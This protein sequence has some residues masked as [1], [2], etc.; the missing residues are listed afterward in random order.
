M[1][2]IHH[3]FTKALG[4][5]LLKKSSGTLKITDLASLRKNAI[6]S[7]FQQVDLPVS[8]DPM[9]L[10]KWAAK[11]KGKNKS[12]YSFLS[13]SG[14]FANIKNLLHKDRGEIENRVYENVVGELE[15]GNPS[16]DK[17]D[18]IRMANDTIGKFSKEYKAT[19]TAVLGS[20]QEYFDKVAEAKKIPKETRE[21]FAK[22][23]RTESVMTKLFKLG[24]SGAKIKLNNFTR[25]PEI[26]TLEKM[27]SEVGHGT[28]L[29]EKE[30]LAKNKVYIKNLFKGIL[31]L[32]E[33]LR[34]LI[35]YDQKSKMQDHLNSLAEAL[36]KGAI[37][38]D[39]SLAV[40]EMGT[41]LNNFRVK[42]S[43]L[44]EVKDRFLKIEDTSTKA[45]EI[46][47]ASTL[48]TEIVNLLKS[49]SAR[50]LNKLIQE[51][52]NKKDQGRLIKE[53]GKS[54]VVL[55]NLL[56]TLVYKGEVKNVEAFKKAY[57]GE[58]QRKEV[59]AFAADENKI[60]DAIKNP[61][62]MNAMI[63]KGFDPKK[64]ITPE[65]MRKI[66]QDIV[67]NL[68]EDKNSL[69]RSMLKNKK[70]KKYMRAQGGDLNKLELNRLIAKVMHE[71]VENQRLGLEKRIQERFG[72]MVENVVG[73][74]MFK[75][76]VN[77]TVIVY[78]KS[79]LKSSIQSVV[80]NEVKDKFEFNP[81]TVDLTKNRLFGKYA[82]KIGVT[83]LQE[84]DGEI[85]KELRDM[86][87]RGSKA[88]KYLRFALWMRDFRGPGKLENLGILERL[89]NILDNYDDEIK[90]YLAGMDD[91]THPGDREA[92]KKYE[93]G[94]AKGALERKRRVYLR[95]RKGIDPDK[96]RKEENANIFKMVNQFV[97]N[98][99]K[100]ARIYA[101][102]KT[103]LGKLGKEL[104]KPL[105][106]A[107]LEIFRQLRK[108]DTILIKDEMGNIKEVPLKGRRLYQEHAAINQMFY[109]ILQQEVNRKL[110]QD[111]EYIKAKEM[112]QF[113]MYSTRY[114]QLQRLFT[115][116]FGTSGPTR[117][118]GLY[119]ETVARESAAKLMNFE[120]SQSVP[121]EDLTHLLHF[122]RQMAGKGQENVGDYM[123]RSV[124]RTI[125]NMIENAQTIEELEEVERYVSEVI[126]MRYLKDIERRQGG[127]GY[128]LRHST[129]QDFEGVPEERIPKTQY[130]QKFISFHRVRIQE[131]MG[132]ANTPGTTPIQP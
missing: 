88:S 6:G 87:N 113:Q 61:I 108:Q 53:L 59:E 120:V 33:P 130:L 19:L 91:D 39:V 124:F 123:T 132:Q 117:N 78:Y 98:N 52:V 48:E 86:A 96:L 99:P 92:G 51:K 9:D 50:D 68:A 25:L 22:A 14:N 15:K 44:I 80:F 77:G 95:E 58:L 8:E 38:G 110:Y 74:D 65:V 126:P 131:R 47:S 97:Q 107:Q 106:A 31:R 101:M 114:E 128:V 21:K 60:I 72:S 122:G 79:S 45:F 56:R 115:H 82:K 94:R 12:L 36:P 75:R 66:R 55:A 32:P 57:D 105:R 73:K 116:Q 129:S 10:F 112:A 18:I 102:K 27:L 127:Q 37:K 42:V 3:T 28:Y 24:A 2:Y 49:G 54:S 71:E 40:S 84:L 103:T 109:N 17:K 85:M 90:L 4:G 23:Y 118:T 111:P 69:V 13:K 89:N 41:M 83:T 93:E 64:H 20:Y 26:S 1:P 70:I 67:E 30:R 100:L 46:H 62:H 16:A 7:V 125:P 104:N 34:S 121:E 5:L 11:L 29:T 35:T 43:W 119:Q 63:K 76:L 81:L